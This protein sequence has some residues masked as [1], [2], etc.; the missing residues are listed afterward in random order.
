MPAAWAPARFAGRPGA[1]PG[2]PRAGP[3]PNGRGEDEDQADIQ[4][5]RLDEGAALGL[6]DR[7]KGGRYR[8]T[9]VRAA[10]QYAQEPDDAKYPG[11]L[12]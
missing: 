12:R 9:H 11:V 5:L 8:A 10:P 4:Q 2:E 3:E 6:E 1:R 7:L